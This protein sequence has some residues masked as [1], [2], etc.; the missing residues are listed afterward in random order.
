MK[1]IIKYLLLTFFFFNSMGLNAMTQ[2]EMEKIVIK[3]VKVIEHEKG[4]ILFT[5]QKVKM[6]LIS[7]KNHDRMRIITPIREYS[8]LTEKVKETIMEANFHSALDARYALRDGVIY[9]AFIHP[10]SPLSKA[11][12]ESA[13][14]QVATLAQTFGSTYSSTELSFQGTK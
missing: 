13:L 3:N 12:I 4:T 10:L 11:E 8:L 6:M 7:D 14:K 9:S 2:D 5:Y 1:K